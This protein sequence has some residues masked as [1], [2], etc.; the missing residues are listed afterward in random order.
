MLKVFFLR[1]F[2]GTVKCNVFL[3]FGKWVLQKPARWSNIYERENWHPPICSTRLQGNSYGLL[4][5]ESF[6][7]SKKFVLVWGMNP[8][9]TPVWGARSANWTN[10]KASDLT[11]MD[12]LQFIGY[13]RH[14][15]SKN[16]LSWK[17]EF[18]NQ[19]CWRFQM[20]VA[21]WMKVLLEKG[22]GTSAGK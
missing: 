14:S 16:A 8:G 4:K 22:R 2:K 13:S 6:L 1:H 18:Q 5:N 7:V 15:N 10:Q 21:S 20:P 9:P 12:F 19:D 17:P 11:G 3:Q